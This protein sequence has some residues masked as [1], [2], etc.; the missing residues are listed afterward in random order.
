MSAENV[1]DVSTANARSMTYG[2]L[3]QAFKYPEK[4][5]PS[6]LS[7]LEYTEAFDPAASEL[8]CSLR[9]YSYAS[10]THSTAL[11][12]ELLRFYHYFGLNRSSEA[13][14]PDHISVELEFMQFLAVLEVNAAGRGDSVV[15]IQK[16]QRDFILRHLKV[17]V[18]GISSAYRA[19]SPAGRALVEMTSE[20]VDTVLQYLCEEVG[21]GGNAAA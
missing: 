10:D 16:A 9:E 8:A 6:L 17:L 19:E 14:M 1:I 5:Q 21:L 12:E 4:G 7:A 11:N 2:R 15:S 3:A 18:D 13:L 20:V